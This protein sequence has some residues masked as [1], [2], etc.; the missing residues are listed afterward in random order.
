MISKAS[1]PTR[2]EMWMDYLF[3]LGAKMTLRFCHYLHMLKGNKKGL[4]VLMYC[5]HR[6]LRVSYKIHW[7]ILSPAPM[8]KYYQI[9]LLVKTCIQIISS[10]LGV[11]IYQLTF[12]LFDNLSHILMRLA[13]FLHCFYD[14]FSCDE[15][16]Q[17]WRVRLTVTVCPDVQSANCLANITSPSEPQG[18][19]G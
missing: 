3:I 10:K 8:F 14:W 12:W 9:I 18:P 13:L 17:G 7:G 1:L 2:T 4:S 19:F 6:W 11:I 15:A 16:L 5:I